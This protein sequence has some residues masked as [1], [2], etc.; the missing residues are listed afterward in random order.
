MAQVRRAIFGLVLVALLWA[1]NK[2]TSSDFVTLGPVDSIPYRAEAE[3]M[4]LY[5][6]G[7]LHPPEHLVQKM[8]HE[9]E[10]IR[11]SIHDSVVIP[12]NVTFVP[13]W[14]VHS[15]IVRFD[16]TNQQLVLEGTH[17]WWNTVCE[18]YG[19]RNLSQNEGL[20]PRIFFDVV[21]KSVSHPVELAKL[22][23]A[24][25]VSG[26]VY[27]G[28][29]PMHTIKDNGLARVDLGSTVTYYVY[30]V[31][32]PDVFGK[33]YFV[34][35]QDD[36]VCIRGTHQN[37]PD[38]YESIVREKSPAYVD[39]LFESIEQ[40]RPLWVDSARHYISSVRSAPLFQS[41]PQ[42]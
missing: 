1:S 17:N 32:H 31:I 23:N 38:N 3:D 19:L 37:F 28:N 36:R 11:H 20:H 25:G 29:S 2:A 18:K 42:D 5:Y 33:Y 8:S 39:S 41:V 6:S 14:W 4:A 27:L 30:E 12:K 35:I 22:I 24:E 21:A 40:Y 16:P 13:P 9:L 7:Q 10:L 26:L 15:I 34:E